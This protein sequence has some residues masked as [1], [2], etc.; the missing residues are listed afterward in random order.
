VKSLSELRNIEVELDRFRTRTIAAAAFVLI[1]FGLLVFRWVVLQVVRHDDLAA[2]AEAN[3]IGVVPVVPNRGLIVDRNGVVLATNYPAYTLEITPSKVD[4]VEATI[5]E[6]G[7]VVEV[8]Q[9]DRRRF[10]RLMD[11]SKSFE[12]LPIRTKLSEEEVARFVA[13][14]FRFRGVEIKARLF[15]SYPHGELA[16]HLVGYIGRINQEE[17]KN[18]VDNWP[19]E[20]QANYRA[21]STSASSASSRATRP[22]CTAPRASSRSRPRP[23]AARCAS[24][25][26]GRRRPATRSRSRSTSSSRARSRRCTATGAARSSRSIRATA[27]CCPSSP[28]RPSTRTS[29]STASTRRTG[30]S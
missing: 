24:S 30:R 19:D 7:K 8:T 9:R 15:R 12:S 1:A 3:R 10:K 11:E 16:S 13:Q 27:R 5:N 28:S 26:A 21:P 17:K 23:A 14:R 29:S 2:Q 6:I 18:I 22:S 20:D 4:D 25:R